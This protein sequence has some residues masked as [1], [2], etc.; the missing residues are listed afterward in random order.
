[1]GLVESVIGILSDNDYLDLFEGCPIQGGKGL[2]GWGV[3]G[4][5]VSVK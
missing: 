3:D 2:F 1:M 4:V 5:V